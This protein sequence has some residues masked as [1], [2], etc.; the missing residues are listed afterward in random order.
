LKDGHRI[1]VPALVLSQ[2]EADHAVTDDCRRAVAAPN[3][4]ARLRR[5]DK[6]RP[7]LCLRLLKADTGYGEGAPL[8]V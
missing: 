1:N 7:L 5:V 3:A 8:R 4:L 6:R 2:S